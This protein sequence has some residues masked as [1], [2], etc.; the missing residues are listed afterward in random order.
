MPAILHPDAQAQIK[1]GS[2]LVIAAHIHD[3]LGHSWVNVGLAGSDA[4]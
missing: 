4:P 2:T 3:G 1:P